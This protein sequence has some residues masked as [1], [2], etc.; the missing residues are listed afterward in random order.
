MSAAATDVVVIGGGLNGLVAG[1]WLAK[2]KLT[3]IVLEGRSAPGGAAVTTEFVSGFR[4]PSLSHS[5]GPLHRDVV[6]ALDLD[7]AGLAFI[8]PDPSLTT[9]GRHGE[10]MIFH[11]DQVLTAA[12]IHA[13]STHDAVRWREFLNSTQRIAGVVAALQRHAPPPIDHPS[14]GDVWRLLGAGRKARAL[15]RRD[16]ERLV[17]WLPMAVADLAAEWFETDLL[18]A[19]IAARAVFGN[20]AGPL[21]AGTGAMLLQRLG[22]DP[23]PVGS[24]TTVRGGPGALTQKLVAVAEQAGARVTVDARATRVTVEHGR[25]TGVVL[26][27]GSHV[28]A[29]AVISAVDPRQT[30]LTLADPE[31]LPPSFLQR[32]RQFRVRGVTAKVNLALSELP[33]FTALHG[34]AVP[35]RGRFLV[36]PDVEYLERAFDAAKYGD[37]AAEPWLELAI[38][39]VADPSLAPEGRHVLSVYV[40]DAPRHLHAT[41]WARQRNSIFRSVMRVLEPHVPD[42]ESIVI[43]GDVITP[44]DLE[45][46]WGLSGGHIFHGE[47]TLDQSWLAGYR[48]PIDGLYLASAGSHPGGGLTGLPGL[49]AARTAAGDLRR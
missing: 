23:M 33:T 30:F 9:L 48:T 28:P 1:A 12:S 6:R 11:R 18:R 38:P 20:L 46:Q 21:S 2:K 27:N 35:L 43:D 14:A 22:E 45:R 4:G 7:R 17:R 8:T 36:A 37:V 3:T 42:L 5:L 39:T 47:T 13:H 41:E 26:A 25:V 24:G 31:D 29:R 19:A 15:D 32:M 34:D 49:L 44:E 40:H 16:L 10:T